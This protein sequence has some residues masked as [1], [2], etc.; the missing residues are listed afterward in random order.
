[1]SLHVVANN[2]EVH[3]Y[4]FFFSSSWRNISLPPVKTL[5]LGDFW[6]TQVKWIAGPLVLVSWDWHL[7][8]FWVQ[9]EKPS[10]MLTTTSPCSKVGPGAAGPLQGLWLPMGPK[11]YNGLG[12]VHFHRLGF[13]RSPHRF[14]CKVSGWRLTRSPRISGCTPNPS[15]PM[16]LS[17]TQAEEDFPLWLHQVF[18]LHKGT[19]TSLES[20]Q[21]AQTKELD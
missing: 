12:Y 8:L 21:Q 13:Y 20:G 5:P 9:Q 18:G 1:M 10:R 14:H 7:H 11:E 19:E 3:L 2:K 4:F 15:F 6:F 17:G 16:G